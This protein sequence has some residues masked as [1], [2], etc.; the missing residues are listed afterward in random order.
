MAAA[1]AAREGAR[2]R[3]SSVELTRPRVTIVN[4]SSGLASCYSH[5]D[6][7]VRVALAVHPP[8]QPHTTVA[9]MGIGGRV[10]AGRA[11]GRRLT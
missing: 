1:A 7:R 3:S 11:Q 10:S 2:P 8:V 5:L 9:T 4:S 6:E